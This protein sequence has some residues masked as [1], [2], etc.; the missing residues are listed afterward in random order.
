MIDD[1]TFAWL[2]FGISELF[3]LNAFFEQRAALDIGREIGQEIRHL[4][5]PSWWYSWVKAARILS[6]GSLIYIAVV[7][8]WYYP[9]IVAG[10]SFVITTIFPVPQSK[11]VNVIEKLSS[12]GIRLR[13][14]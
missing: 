3:L 1:V 12:F 4:V 8:I 5:L 2:L 13:D 10:L 6:F 7:W 9:L 11:Y 14:F